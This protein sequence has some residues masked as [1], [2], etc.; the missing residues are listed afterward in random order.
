MN[1]YTLLKDVPS[2]MFRQQYTELPLP[3][4]LVVT[5]PGFIVP[6]LAR[7]YFT[8]LYLYEDSVVT[9][10][11]L[12]QQKGAAFHGTAYE[13]GVFLWE[14]FEDYGDDGHTDYRLMGWV[15]L[16]STALAPTAYPVRGVSWPDQFDY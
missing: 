15:L 5:Q 9:Y 12:Q 4:E 13:V 8:D 1:L 2:L 3:T 6:R 7:V 14:V 11:E 10:R 16:P